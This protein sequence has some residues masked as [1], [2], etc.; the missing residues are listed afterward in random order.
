M[1]TMLIATLILAGSSAM[2]SDNNSF[3][4]DTGSIVYSFYCPNE[5][6][7]EYIKETATR[8][9]NYGVINDIKITDAGS[10]VI[11]STYDFGGK[12]RKGSLSIQPGAGCMFHK[13]SKSH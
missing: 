13:F 8:I 9:G 11:E 12:S 6:A 3:R 2:A 1:K 10:I 4:S 5:G 7:I